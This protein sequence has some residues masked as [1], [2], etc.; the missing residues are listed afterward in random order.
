MTPR[1][2]LEI[3]SSVR[4]HGRGREDWSRQEALAWLGRGA[5]IGWRHE[6]VKY[7]GKLHGCVQ[8]LLTFMTNCMAVCKHVP[9]F[10]SETQL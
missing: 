1:T 8:T 9:H 10:W 3:L 4:L 7:Y 2:C 6:F 5:A